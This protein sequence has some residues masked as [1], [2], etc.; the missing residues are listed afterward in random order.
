MSPVAGVCTGVVVVEVAA[1]VVGV[2]D[3]DANPGSPWVSPVAGSCTG[4]VEVE[5]SHTGSP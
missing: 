2:V 3:V 4:V 5:V 1:V